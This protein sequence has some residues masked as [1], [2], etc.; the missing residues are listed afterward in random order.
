MPSRTL[1]R[2]PFLFGLG[3]MLLE[4]AYEAPIQS[5]R[6]PADVGANGQNTEYYT[7]GRVRLSA[8]K[9]LRPRYAELARKCVQCDFGPR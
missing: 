3:V 8:S 4:I 7:A 2:N 5:L 6:K 9:L 1:V